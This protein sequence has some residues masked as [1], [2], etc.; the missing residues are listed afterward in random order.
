MLNPAT[1]VAS[2][3]NVQYYR[4]GDRFLLKGGQTYTISANVAPSQI[5]IFKGTNTTVATTTSATLTYTPTEDVEVWIDIYVANSMLPEGGIS[6]VYGMLELGDTAHSYEPYHLITETDIDFPTSICSGL[7]DVLSGVLTITHILWMKNTASMNNDPDYPGWT[8]AGVREI[9]GTGK[10][11]AIN[12]VVN[13]GSVYGVNT[14]N[15]NDIVYLPKSLYDGMTQ[16]QWKALAMDIQIAMELETPM[17]RNLTPNQI[18][19]LLGN[20]TIWSDANGDIEVE[21]RADTDK[22]INDLISDAIA[23][24][25]HAANGGI[26]GVMTPGA[27]L[28]VLNDKIITNPAGASTI[29]V[30]TSSNLPITP[31]YVDACTFYGLARAAGANMASLS[32]VIVGQYPQAQKTAIQTMLGIEADIPLVET[33]TGATASIT[34][35]PNVRYICDT[36]ISELTIT[37]PASGSIVVRFT[38]GSNC[39]VSLPQTVKLPE[40]FDISSLEAGTTYEIII[41]DGVYG[42]VMS[43]A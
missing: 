19:T 18:M 17:R 24:Q 29:Q 14:N 39:I 23:N 38:A 21:Y 26:Y 42:G 31:L 37:P 25:P 12:G 27:G 35:M 30:G 28:T 32:G 2:G 40:W 9:V 10:N 22:F 16:D 13:V 41:T 15:A 1:R 3:N 8:N 4:S 6:A 33:I 43:W 11:G 7:L 36:A 34:G 20:N 5:S